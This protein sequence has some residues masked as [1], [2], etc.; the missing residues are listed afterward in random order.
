M[1][2]NPNT[3]ANRISRPCRDAW[4]TDDTQVGGGD[5]VRRVLRSRAKGGA[6]ARNGA[7]E[8]WRSVVAWTSKRTPSGPRS[9]ASRKSADPPGPRACHRRSG[10]AAAICSSDIPCGGMTGRERRDVWGRGNEPPLG[11]GLRFRA[12]RALWPYSAKRTRISRAAAAAAASAY[13][14]DPPPA[15]PHS[16][17]VPSSTACA[18]GGFPQR[19]GFVER[20]YHSCLKETRNKE[21]VRRYAQGKGEGK[22]E[23]PSLMGRAAPRASSAGPP[24]TSPPAQAPAHARA[25]QT[26]SVS[27]SGEAGRS[28]AHAAPPC[29]RA[30][31][32][33]EGRGR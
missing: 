12:L 16:S 17:P 31:G 26:R 22:S 4:R 2:R 28:A 27:E 6:V 7:E 11:A 30:T 23:A 33:K 29:A 18:F 32:S 10:E 13:P 21:R 14:P 9:V 8:R 1:F 15:D 19:K 25:R 20:A 3:A 5:G 24:R